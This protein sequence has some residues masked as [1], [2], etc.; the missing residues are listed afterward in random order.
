MLGDPRAWDG[1][2]DG[3]GDV[4]GVEAE[5]RLIDVQAVER[6]VGLKQRDSNV[7]RV[8]L[9]L[10]DSERNRN[11]VRANHE[12]LLARFPVPGRDVLAALRAGRDP[13]GSG[14]VFR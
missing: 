8:V 9:L 3:A 11:A 14:I 10:H 12:Q 7:E 13:G 2:I 6:R 1:W 4:I 5:M